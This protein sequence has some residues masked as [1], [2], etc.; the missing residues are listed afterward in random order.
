MSYFRL[1]ALPFE[2]T[3]QEF[4]DRHDRVYVVENNG[5]GQLA[6]LLLMEYPQFATR[7]ISLAHSDGLP[8]SA[9]WMT[10]AVLEQEQ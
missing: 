5:D 10:A 8:L 7:I 3:M 9:R 4:L 2:D 6:K 1:R